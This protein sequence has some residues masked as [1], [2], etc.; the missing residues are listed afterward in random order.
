MSSGKCIAEHSARRSWRAGGKLE[1]KG[2]DGPVL[3]TDSPV[4]HKPRHNLWVPSR[5]SRLKAFSRAPLSKSVAQPPQYREVSP[6]KVSK[7]DVYLQFFGSNTL[8]KEN[9]A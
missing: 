9:N 1:T 6:A 4:T 2:W 5:G 3:G 7:A 8:P